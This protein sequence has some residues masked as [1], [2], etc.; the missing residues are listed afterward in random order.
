MK[1]HQKHANLIKPDGGKYHRREYGLIGAPCG[2]I[3]KAVEEVDRQ[4]PNYRLGY[5]DADHGQSGEAEKFSVRYTD[6]ITY[7]QLNYS[8]QHRDFSLRSSFEQCDALLVNANHFSADRQI[9]FIHEKKK[10]SLSRK[11]DRLTDVRAFVLCDKGVE[12]FDFLKA[13]LGNWKNIPS[14]SIED[15]TSLAQLIAKDIEE[16]IP[17]ITGLVLS[18]GKSQRMGLDKG[19]IAYH[20]KSQREHLADILNDLCDDVWLSL[21]PDQNADLP[22]SVVEDSFIGLGPFGGILSAFRSDP[23]RAYLTLPC[24]VPFIDKG[25]VSRLIQER[26]PSKLATCYHNRETGF[27]EPLI[28]IWEP[29]AYER[30]LHFLAL[31]YSCPRKVLI[32]SDVKEVQPSD[33]LFLFNANT[34]EERT[35]AEKLLQKMSR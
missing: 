8:D 11:L 20:S 5:M 15:E 4:L 30:L 12:V 2:L 3:Q 28:T 14:I 24:D 35:H 6:K 9:V 21:A 1:V 19:T 26:D 29:R 13:H 23:N 22:Y 31:G 10:E 25:F 7:H 27:P 32:N 33:D 16:S 18:G 34:P 17:L